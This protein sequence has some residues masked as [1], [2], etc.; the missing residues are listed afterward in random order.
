M[1]WGEAKGQFIDEA[2]RHWGWDRD[3]KLWSAKEERLKKA[4]GLL[5]RKAGRKGWIERVDSGWQLTPAGFDRLRGRKLSPPQ[6]AIPDSHDSDIRAFLRELQSSLHPPLAHFDV[7]GEMPPEPRM[8]DEGI[9]RHPLFEDLDF[10]AKRLRLPRGGNPYALYNEIKAL[11]ITIKEKRKLIHAKLQGLIPKEFS[12]LDGKVSAAQLALDSILREKALREKVPEGPYQE[13]WLIVPRLEGQEI[14][15]GGFALRG[16]CS[17]G[18]LPS[19]RESWS[20][21]LIRSEEVLLENYRTQSGLQE[22]VEETKFRCE[23]AIAQ[24]A[25]QVHYPG[26]CK[27]RASEP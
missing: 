6:E 18:D 3:S 27:F 9:E 10:H 5:H 13:E 17:A 11:V 22:D 20:R 1:I 23:T 21:L 26:R 24:M 7:A 25:Y 15:V 2:R 8:L 16:N 19:V 4:F 14:K 12:R